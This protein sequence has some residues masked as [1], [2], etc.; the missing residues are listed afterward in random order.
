MTITIFISLFI[1][2]PLLSALN[3][4]STEQPTVKFVQIDAMYAMPPD[5]YK[6]LPSLFCYRDGKLAKRLIGTEI[7]RAGS[8]SA[9][10]LEWM[11]AELGVLE[12]ELEEAPPVQSGIQRA[13]SRQRDLREEEECVDYGI[14]AE[15][16]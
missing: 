12:T 10:G 3:V 1:S 11:L 9:P 5:K 4:L 16:D 13:G 14:M 2:K 7:T 15:M 6:L 8:P